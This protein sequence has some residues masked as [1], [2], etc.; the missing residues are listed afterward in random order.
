MLGLHTPREALLTSL[1]KFTLPVH[2]DYGEGKEEGGRGGGG[3]GGEGEGGEGEGGG[4]GGVQLTRKHL[5]CI[6]A[7]FSMAHC[8]SSVGI[9]D[10][11]SWVLVL[12][13]LQ[14]L[15]LLL[16]TS[17]VLVSTT[18]SKKKKKHAILLQLLLSFI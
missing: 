5:Q 13:T 1:C 3:G 6:R 15:D 7:L 8:M 18:G 9:M 10:V 14:Q 17:I 2:L 11:D 4:R 16:K 12:E